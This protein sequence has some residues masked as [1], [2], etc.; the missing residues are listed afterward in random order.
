MAQ[1]G[2]RSAAVSTPGSAG[3]QVTG[4]PSEFD[5]IRKYFTRPVRHTVEGIG[6]DCALIAARPG[7]QVAISTDLLVEGTHFLPD[8]DAQ[9]L[10]HKTLAVNLSDLAAA[11][12]EPRWATLAVALP[13]A[14]EAWIAAFASGFF[15]LAER[16]SLDLI[17][18][19][20]TRGPRS[21]CV[22]VMGEVPEG[23]SL[24]RSGAIAGDDVWVS[25]E[26]G[27]AALALAARLGRTAIGANAR[28]AL[29]HRLDAPQPRVELGLALRGLASAAIDVS[30]GLVGDLGHICE[31][32]MLAARIEYAL[33][34]QPQ[35]LLALADAPLR[36]DCLLSGGDDYELLFTA[37]ATCRD[38]LGALSERLGLAL[39][40]I[41]SMHAGEPRATV[42]DGS[43][44]PIAHRGR[45]YDHFA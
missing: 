6:D 27:G 45:G 42:L 3:S 40:R 36:S 41:G 33:L 5:L 7:M 14:D 10:G 19:D 30:D 29:D 35:A 24:K 13:E 18:G 20:T 2:S 16:H 28:A 22:T 17:G 15:A 1:D 25:G 34:P 38:E 32:S 12:A 37:P 43:G 11:G 44:N 39:T 23:R 26:L 4:K 9:L 21:F 8:A 31:R